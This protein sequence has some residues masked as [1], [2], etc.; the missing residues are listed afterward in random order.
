MPRVWRDVFGWAALV[1]AGL[2]LAALVATPP[3]TGQHRVRVDLAS[4]LAPAVAAAVL[5][6]VRRNLP[7]RLGWGWLLVAGSG[8]AFS[9]AAGLALVGGRHDL[10]GR[11]G[12]AVL[13]SLAVPLVALAVRSLCRELAARRLVPV[14]ALAPYALLVP[15]TRD[16][17]TL[18]LGA[19]ALACGVVGSERGRPPWW[20]LL[21]GLAL[22]TAA[23]LVPGAA[24]LGGSLI[25][26]YFIRRRPILNLL[27]GVG[28][29]VPIGLSRLAGP[30]WLA[31]LPEVPAGVPVGVPPQ[32][33]WLVWVL[34]DVLLVLLACGPVLITGARKVR[35]TPGWPLL[36]GAALAVG[37]AVGAGLSRGEIERSFLPFFPWLLVPAVAPE[38]GTDPAGVSRT[39]LLP[40]GVGAAAAVL[41]AATLRSAG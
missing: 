28:V 33:S 10:A 25:V 12:G 9:W 4:L 15:G 37:F 1:A 32:R 20:A 2:A 31:R 35:R 29:L 21:A 38:P 16:A 8:A 3:F 19:T 5:F 36:V 27:S 40:L 24:W 41:M 34:L 6:A 23:L 39:P 13:G 26:T 11:L 30:G 18:A 14:L 22:G 7:E 17:A